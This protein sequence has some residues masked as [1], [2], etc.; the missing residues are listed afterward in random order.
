M[1]K[2]HPLYQRIVEQMIALD[3]REFQVSE[4]QRL[5]TAMNYLHSG[6]GKESLLGGSLEQT[7]DE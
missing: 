2:F 6:T 5:V 4:S 3:R 1:K 7:T